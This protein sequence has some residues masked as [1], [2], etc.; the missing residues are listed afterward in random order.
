MGMGSGIC[1]AAA[2][3]GGVAFFCGKMGANPIPEAISGS[4]MVGGLTGF[5]AFEIASGKDKK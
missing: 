4:L 2:L 1:G 3:L 5:V